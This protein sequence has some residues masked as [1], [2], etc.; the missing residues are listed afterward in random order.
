VGKDKADA[1]ARSEAE[2]QRLG[3]LL[4]AER[5]RAALLEKQLQKAHRKIARLE[6]EAGKVSPATYA[7]KAA[8]QDAGDGKAAVAELQRRCAEMGRKI[9]ALR[10]EMETLRQQVQQRPPTQPSWPVYP[11]P[12]PYSTSPRPVPN[13]PSQPLTPP[14]GNGPY[15]QAPVVPLNEAP[16][17]G[18]GSSAR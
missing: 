15:Y 6:K 12:T 5:E 17:G 16:S 4:K 3:A 10:G 11:D 14:G 2:A 1:P 18:A 8:A 13:Y 7:E 9:D